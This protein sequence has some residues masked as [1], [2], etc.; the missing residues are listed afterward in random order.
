[1]RKLI[2]WLLCCACLSVAADEQ[3]VMATLAQAEAHHSEALQ[4]EHGWSSTETYLEEARAALAAG[5]IE[6]ATELAGRALLSAEGSLEQAETERSA[7]RERAP[8]DPS[9]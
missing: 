6:A 2:P 9:R 7:W 1:M 8:S 4:M 3:Q 5:D